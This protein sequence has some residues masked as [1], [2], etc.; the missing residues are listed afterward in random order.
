M[1]SCACHAFCVLFMHVDTQ[2]WGTVL[3]A[4]IPSSCHA[5]VHAM[6]C[7]CLLSLML[8]SCT[9]AWPPWSRPRTTPAPRLAPSHCA[10]A[11]C[12]ITAAPVPPRP[13]PWSLSRPYD[14]AGF[15]TAARPPAHDPLLG[16]HAASATHRW[17]AACPS[18]T[19]CCS[20][21]PCNRH[22]CTAYFTPWESCA[23]FGLISSGLN[24]LVSTL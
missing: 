8:P 16:G 17:Y 24:R 19:G 6:A 21:P 10:M 9:L 14:P 1:L 4:H 13:R 2:A 5:L 15:G 7:S 11:V 22:M 23:L 20:T 12:C 3:F 18:L